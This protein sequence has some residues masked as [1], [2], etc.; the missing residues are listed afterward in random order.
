MYPTDYTSPRFKCICLPGYAGKL[1]TVVVR[2]CRGYNNG[3]RI[4]GL[5]KVFDENMKLFDV[6]CD[7]DLNSSATWTLVQSY[8]L[9]N[10]QLFRKKSF[11]LDFPVNENTHN[12]KEYRLS[13]SKIQTIQDDSKKF[14]I[15]CNYDTEGVAYRDYLQ[16]AKSKIDIMTFSGHKCSLVE[17]ID[18]RGHNCKQCTAW[19]VQ[20][21]KIGLHSDSYY[22]SV[23]SCEFRPSGSSKCG[24]K[25][26]DNFGYFSCINNGHRCSSSPSATTQIWVG[27]D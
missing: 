14:R 15:T 21:S 17:R 27:G 26:E 7:F 3:S 12:W 4:P 25:G 23:R 5:Y 24:G 10:T 13:K 20:D 1:C 8:E 9:R 22:T 11:F 2:S 18:I 16:A 19:I 6:Y